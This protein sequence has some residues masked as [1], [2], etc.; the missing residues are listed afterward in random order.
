VLRGRNDPTGLVVAAF[1]PV[2]A[3]YLVSPNIFPTNPG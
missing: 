1:I 2:T 3:V